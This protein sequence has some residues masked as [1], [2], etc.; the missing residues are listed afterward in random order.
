[1]EEIFNFELDENFSK[2]NGIV[3]GTTA[4]EINWIELNTAFGNMILLLRYLILKN[5][6]PTNEIE[7]VYWGSKSYFK[8]TNSHE[9]YME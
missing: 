3:I 4:N 6:V 1:M 9:Q 7:L 5:K 8:T 2:L